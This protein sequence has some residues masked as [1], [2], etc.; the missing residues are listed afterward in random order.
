MVQILLTVLSFHDIHWNMVR[1]SIESFEVPDVL[2]IALN[3]VGGKMT[4]PQS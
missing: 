2:N 4:Y 3:R 1:L